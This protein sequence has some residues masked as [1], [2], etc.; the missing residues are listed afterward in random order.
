MM[1]INKVIEIR[2]ILTHPQSIAIEGTTE[3][4]LKF[5]MGQVKRIAL[6]RFNTI[7]PRLH[8]AACISI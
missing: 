2:G 4:D 7:Y 6:E 8:S 1:K 5:E 3:E